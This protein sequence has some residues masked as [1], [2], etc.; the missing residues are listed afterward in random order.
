MGRF[1]R[2]NVLQSDALRLGPFGQ[3]I[4]DE[5]RPVVQANRQ[6]R[7]AYLHQ[8]VQ[9]PDD[10]RSRQAGVD[11]DAQTLAVEFVDDVEGSE[12]PSGPQR[13]GHQ[14][15]IPALFGLCSRLQWPL[16][17]RRQSLLATP[18]QVQPQ[19]AV[20]AP[21]HRLA[22]GLAL[23]AGAVVQQAGNAAWSEQ[24]RWLGRL[25]ARS[26]RVRTSGLERPPRDA[27]G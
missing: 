9:G 8:F 22:P 5:L 23:V 27:P 13:I 6:W 15:A 1:S 10:T 17:A 3:C 19:L 14:V 4:S 7:T 12:A 26:C 16:D 11:L 24:R 20:H 25:A 2:L 21:Q 18:G